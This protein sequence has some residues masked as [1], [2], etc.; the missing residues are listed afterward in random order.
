[1]NSSNNEKTQFNRTSINKD[2]KKPDANLFSTTDRY[3]IVEIPTAFFEI[4]SLFA[5]DCENNLYYCYVQGNRLFIK[6][7]FNRDENDLMIRYGEGISELI[8]A[9]VEFINKR[10][11]NMTKL[12]QMLQKIQKQYNTGRISIECAHTPEIKNWCKKHG[13]VEEGTSSCFFEV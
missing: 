9:R 3:D 2:L 8:V 1:M 4:V 10:K 5:E 12:Y 7:I 6:G 13:F 11:G